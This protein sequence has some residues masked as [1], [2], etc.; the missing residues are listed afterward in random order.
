MET[1]SSRKVLFKIFNNNIVII[2]GWIRNTTV[3]LVLMSFERAWLRMVKSISW[4]DTEIP[5]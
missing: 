1:G 2:Q 5:Q 3:T 4:D